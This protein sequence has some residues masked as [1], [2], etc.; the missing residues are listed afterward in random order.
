MRP[1]RIQLA[2]KG[3]DLSKRIAELKPLRMPQ[4]YCSA[5]LAGLEEMKIPVDN[6]LKYGFYEEFKEGIFP[7]WNF[8]KDN[9]GKIWASRKQNCPSSNHDKEE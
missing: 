2:K 7:D 5:I 9:D 8:I 6:K 4:G 1:N 3:K